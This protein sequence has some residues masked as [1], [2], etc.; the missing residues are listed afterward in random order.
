M[1]TPFFMG[2]PV[3]ITFLQD[4]SVSA[5]NGHDSELGSLKVKRMKV[6]SKSRIYLK[7]HLPTPFFM[8]VLQRMTFLQDSSVSAMNGHDSELGSMKSK[9]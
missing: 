1:P 7:T 9:E 6:W 2:I 4:S 5:L 8:V 3:S